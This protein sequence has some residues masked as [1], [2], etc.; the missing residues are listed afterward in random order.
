MAIFS[1]KSLENLLSQ[2]GLQ[3]CHCV[4]NIG[5]KFFILNF[6]A[7]CFLNSDET[8]CIILFLVD[9][10][11]LAYAFVQ[12]EK[13]FDNK[14]LFGPDNDLLSLGVLGKGE[15]LEDKLL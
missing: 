5:Y 3:I 10:I 7:I 1:M 14:T 2:H 6:F 12:I 11:W 9:S 15:K 4:P 8:G 13:I